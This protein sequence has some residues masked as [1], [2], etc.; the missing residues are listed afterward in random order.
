MESHNLAMNGQIDFWVGEFSW[1]HN[2]KED[3][4]GKQLQQSQQL[5]SAYQFLVN[6][7]TDWSMDE[8]LVFHWWELITGS[9][10]SITLQQMGKEQLFMTMYWMQRNKWMAMSQLESKT[11]TIFSFQTCSVE[12][13]INRPEVHFWWCI[14]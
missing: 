8:F 9:I 13:T 14:N 1:V 12:P 5:A 4:G 3:I 11:K 10:L 2:I 6:Y 7:K